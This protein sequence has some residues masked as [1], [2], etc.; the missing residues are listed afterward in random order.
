MT[1]DNK[2]RGG[3]DM[4]AEAGK[5]AAQ[6]EDKKAKKRKE[7]EKNATMRAGRNCCCCEGCLSFIIRTLSSNSTNHPRTKD[8]AF[9]MAKIVIVSC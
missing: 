6:N 2:G 1:E 5:R 9:K 8:F 3:D 7:K 4:G